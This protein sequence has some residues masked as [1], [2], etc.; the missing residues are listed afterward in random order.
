MQ[1]DFYWSDVV[2]WWINVHYVSPG[3]STNLWKGWLLKEL[4]TTRT[5]VL[6]LTPE[7]YKVFLSISRCV[8]LLVYY[9]FNQQMFGRNFYKLCPTEV[10]HN[11]TEVVPLQWMSAVSRVSFCRFTCIVFCPPNQV[12]FFFLLNVIRVLITKLRKT[13][14]AE[15]TTYMKAVRATLILIPLLGVQYILMPWTPHE[16]DNQVIY[17]FV[18]ILSN[19]Q[20]HM[21]DFFKLLFRVTISCKSIKISTTFSYFVALCL[22]TLVS[23]E[24]FYRI[25][26]SGCQSIMI[27]KIWGIGVWQKKLQKKKK[28]ETKQKTFNVKVKTSFWEKSPPINSRFA[29]LIK[30]DTHRLRAKGASTKHWF[31]GGEYLSNHLF[32]VKCFYLILIIL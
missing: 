19:F 20:V 15:S 1:L 26:P 7:L 29:G 3:P 24:E 4:K 18:A 28:K 22:Q 12:N 11:P 27:S 31:E 17:C 16:F 21:C 30:T 23:H 5:F 32:Y 14:C 2:F 9:L 25:Q 8:D 13:H 6:F 10:G